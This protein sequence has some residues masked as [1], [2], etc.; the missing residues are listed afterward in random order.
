MR[1]LGVIGVLAIATGAIA[2]CAAGTTTSSPAP[3]GS[4]AAGSPGAEATVE[5]SLQEWA[6]VPAQVSVPA[7]DVTFR[8]TNTGPEDVHEFVV[9][10]TDLDAGA[11]PT[12]ATGAVDE[13]G[14][15]IEVVGEIEDIPVGES[16]DLT[17][18]LTAGAHV[19]LCNI[20][21]EAE[22]EAHYQLG[23]RTNV[24]VE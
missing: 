10:K 23:M 12:D 16:R 8:V 3:G 5:V 9:L 24:S 4:P 11:L 21:D 20:Y 14:E 19:L 13:A 18:P 15:G 2:G 7:G 6:V 22:Q 17:V 1:L